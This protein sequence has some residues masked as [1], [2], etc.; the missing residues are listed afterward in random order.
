VGR[1]APEKNIAAFLDIETPGSKIV[2]G[3]GPQFA[4]LRAHYPDVHFLGRRL[5]EELAAIY[6]SADVFVFPSRTDTFGN[7][8]LEALASGVPV[9]AYP[10]I[11]PIDVLT[12]AKCGAMS[13]DL[14]QAINTALTLSRAAATRHAARY[15]WSECANIFAHN[16]VPARVPEAVSGA[17][18]GA[19]DSSF[20]SSGKMPPGGPAERGRAEAAE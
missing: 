3:D 7:V 1:I 13:E 11:G 10:V 17:R 8:M 19:L 12:D 14:G 6:R 2:V 18:A 16:L 4:D 9:A 5:G 15:T 20:A